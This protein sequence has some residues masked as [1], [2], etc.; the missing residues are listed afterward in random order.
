MLIL[1]LNWYKF[2]LNRVIWSNGENFA[3]PGVDDQRYSFYLNEFGFGL[4]TE[5]IVELGQTQTKLFDVT[6]PIPDDQVFDVIVIGSGMAGGV[7]ADRLADNGV[8]TLVLGCVLKL[9]PHH[10]GS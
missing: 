7:L 3:I 4:P 1:I 5:P 6:R 10:D 9:Q 2:A 8:N